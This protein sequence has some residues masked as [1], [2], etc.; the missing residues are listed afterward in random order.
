MEYT[1]DNLIDLEGKPI[2]VEANINEEDLARITAQ[3]IVVG[4]RMRAMFGE[5][6]AED[7]VG[8]DPTA[9]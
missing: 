2:T 4:E 6:T 3:A 9:K 7:I 5:I 1:F 8:K